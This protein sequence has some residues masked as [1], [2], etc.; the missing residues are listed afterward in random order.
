MSKCRDGDCRGGPTCP[1]NAEPLEGFT[2]TAREIAAKLDVVMRNDLKSGPGR[3]IMAEC[4]GLLRAFHPDID[5]TISGPPAPH[6][7]C[8]NCD[9]T[10]PEMLRYVEDAP[11]ERRVTYRDKATGRYFVDHHIDMDTLDQGGRNARIL[12]TACDH[13]FAVPDDGSVVEFV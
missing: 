12:C 13:E 7:L 10:D 6:R 1:E 8:P 3:A 9:I 4:I 2:W 5:H 11:A